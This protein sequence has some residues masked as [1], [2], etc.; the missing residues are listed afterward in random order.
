[1]RKRVA[2]IKAALENLELIDDPQV[3]MLLL[4]SCLGF[5][6][7]VFSLR[8]A[9]PEEIA[10]TTR[11]FD[12][13]ISSTMQERLGI[14]LAQEQEKQARLPVAMGGLG[15]ERAEDVAESAYLGNV[16]ATRKL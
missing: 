9:P 4:R 1:M 12:K 8:S 15:I 10:E 6:K 3:E 14:S 2:K 16:L 5:P 13:M 11:E 7:F